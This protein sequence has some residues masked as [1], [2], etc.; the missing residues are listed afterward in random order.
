ME[1][2]YVYQKKRAEF[3]RQCIF[4]DK[5]PDLI[6]NYAANKELGQ[7]YILQDPVSQ[8]SQC[9]PILAEHELNTTRANFVNCGINH[10][11]GGWPKDVNKDDEEQTKRYRRKIE[12][13]DAYNPI[14]M[15]LCKVRMIQT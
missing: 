8:G 14:I 2:Q 9:G 12:K 11:E 10:I 4:S 1:L 5:G 7:N 13:D 6:D 15:Q 3:G